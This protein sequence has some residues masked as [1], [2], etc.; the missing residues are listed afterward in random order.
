MYIYNKFKFS[1]GYRILIYKFTQGLKMHLLSSTPKHNRKHEG[2]K[3]YFIFHFSIFIILSVLK[4]IGC[5]CQ[6]QDLF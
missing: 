3:N 6:K 2:I 5:L 1:L 4:E